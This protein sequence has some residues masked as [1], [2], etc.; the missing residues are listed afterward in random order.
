MSTTPPVSTLSIAFMFLSM[1]IAFGL[2][3]GLAI[4]AKGKYKTKF[5]F[6]PL[7]GGVLGF[8]ISQEIFRI[9]IIQGLLPTFDWYQKFMQMRWPYLIFLSFTA[10]LVEEPARFIVFSILKKHRSFP[11][12]L[13]YGIGHGG[14]EA[15]LLVGFTYINNIVFAFAINSGGSNPLL[16]SL[17]SS[18]V[19]SFT[20]TPSYLFAVAGIERIFAITL[21]IALSLLVLKGF[22]VNRKGLYLLLAFLIHGLVNL[23]AVAAVSVGQQTGAAEP[24]IVSVLLS[25]GLLL[26]VAILS[27]IFIVKQARDWSRGQTIPPTADLPQTPAE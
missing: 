4:W 22:Q 1:L 8:V 18:V 16:S 15:I 26:V 14:I 19:S 27:L 3:I 12:G 7:I 24:Q 21:Q 13:S 25:E 11:D 6:L 20:S 17:P 5:S 2:P 9:P 10:G 23:A